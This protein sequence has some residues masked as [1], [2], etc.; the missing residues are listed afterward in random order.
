[1]PQVQSG[2]ALL[3]DEDELTGEVILGRIATLVK[4]PAAL[5]RMSAAAGTSTTRGA[6]ETVATVVLAV[7]KRASGAGQ[8]GPAGGSPGVGG[9]R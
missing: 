8:A 5:A 9:E 7:G 2:A 6:A 3:I 1:M 4:D